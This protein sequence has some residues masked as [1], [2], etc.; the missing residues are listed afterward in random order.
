ME[1]NLSSEM[2]GTSGWITP[3]GHEPPS[4]LSM[5]PKETLSSSVESRPR[6]EE[7]GHFAG[8]EVAGLVSVGVGV[9][10][11]AG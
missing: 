8:V 7:K 9:D 5:L 3:K 10:S 4:S 1:W 2:A 6:E 11:A